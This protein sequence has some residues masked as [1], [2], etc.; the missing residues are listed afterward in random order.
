MTTL[1]ARRTGNGASRSLR[2]GLATSAVIAI[3]PV[4]ATGASVQ[5]PGIGRSFGTDNGL[6]WVLN[7]F[8]LSFAASICVIGSMADRVGRRQTFTAGVILLTVALGGTTLAPDLPAVIACRGLTG[9][10]A[11]GVIA[12]GTAVLAELYEGPTRTRVFSVLGTVLGSSVAFA[13][14]LAGLSLQVGGWRSWYLLLTVL[15]AVGVLVAR[16]SPTRAITAGGSF[17]HRGA[18]AFVAPLAVFVICIT[19]APTL[20]W[21]SPAVLGALAV[22]AGLAALFVQVE[23]RVAEPMLDLTLLRNK[24]FAIICLTPLAGAFAYVAPVMLLPAYFAGVDHRTAFECGLTLLPA[25]VPTLIVPLTMSVFAHRIRIPTVLVA[26]LSVMGVGAICGVTIGWTSGF[27]FSIALALLGIGFGLM[28]SVVDGAAVST[29]PTER[30]G[31][32]AGLFNTARLGSESV[33]MAVVTSV[34]A[35]LT[36]S[37]RNVRSGDRTVL[38]GTWARTPDVAGAFAHG[39]QVV[40][41]IFGVLSLL[42]AVLA[43]RVLRAG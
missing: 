7:A 10:A 15:A 12:G 32:A 35:T 28:L 14:M 31:M 36:M 18:V 19:E 16:S 23:R 9:L 34:V 4:A 1:Q 27:G 33:A 24:R 38:A 6:S 43:R 37:G 3:V 41:V 30:A 29:V 8:F 20:G 5:L 40:F 22:A 25:T 42:A 21:G 2:R 13:P 39:W 26:S 11:A 17:D